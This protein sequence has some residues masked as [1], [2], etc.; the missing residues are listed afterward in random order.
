MIAVQAAT[1]KGLELL[2]FKEMGKKKNGGF[3]V[4]VQYPGR[5]SGYKV[6]LFIID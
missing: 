6:L 5:D 1:S 3:S 4:S 2:Y